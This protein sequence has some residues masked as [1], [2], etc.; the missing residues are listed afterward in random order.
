M[1]ASV[2]SVYPSVSCWKVFVRCPYCFKR[3]SH[4]GGDGVRPLLGSRGSH[5]GLGEYTLTVDSYSS[6]VGLPSDDPLVLLTFS[7]QAI[8]VGSGVE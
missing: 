6:V 4:G 2:I 1:N 5:C 7:G 3:H 8:A